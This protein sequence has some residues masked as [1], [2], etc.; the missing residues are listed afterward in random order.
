MASFLKPVLKC[1]EKIVC[2]VC[3]WLQGREG[4]RERGGGGG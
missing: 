1:T 2:V 4:K 3:V